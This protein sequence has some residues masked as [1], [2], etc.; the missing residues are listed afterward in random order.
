[1]ASEKNAVNTHGAELKRVVGLEQAPPARATKPAPA[2]APAPTPTA[3][4]ATVSPG[5]QAMN[6]CMM[7]NVQAHQREIEELGKRAQ[8]AAQGGD[9]PKAIAISDTLRQLQMAGCT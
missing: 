5:Q 8:A 4:A 1:S 7:K 3:A 2:P 9:T 6:D